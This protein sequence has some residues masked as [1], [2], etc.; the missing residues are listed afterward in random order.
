VKLHVKPIYG[1]GWRKPDNSLFEVPP[2]FDLEALD[3]G[4]LETLAIAQVAVEDHPLSGLWLLFSPRRLP[5][6]GEF[7]VAVYRQ[8][9]KGS[10][11]EPSE[12]SGFAHIE[13]SN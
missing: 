3:S 1:Y 10:F 5:H 2:P 7:N 12:V 9:P 4:D 6:D 8:R 13:I 11:A